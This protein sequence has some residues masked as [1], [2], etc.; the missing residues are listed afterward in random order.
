MDSKIINKEHKLG[1]LN[2]EKVQITGVTKVISIE[3]QQ[4]ILI[5]DVGKITISGKDLHAGKLDVVAGVLEFTGMVNNIS[6]SDY[7]TTGQKASGFVGR[8]FK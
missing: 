1:I 5:T 4:V 2:R 8:L 3:E 6:Y 7:K